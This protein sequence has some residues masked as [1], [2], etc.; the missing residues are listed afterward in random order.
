MIIKMETI[1]GYDRN[2]EKIRYIYYEIIIDNIR[3]LE[4]K[5]HID[6]WFLLVKN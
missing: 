2:E 5:I 6:V 3:S 4:L 1:N